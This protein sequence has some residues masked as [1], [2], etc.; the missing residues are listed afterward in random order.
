MVFSIL[1]ASMSSFSHLTIPAMC[2]M[3]MHAFLS[4]PYFPTW[5]SSPHS[6]V[7]LGS[8]ALYCSCT[9]LLLVHCLECSVGEGPLLRFYPSP[10]NPKEN[11]VD[12]GDSPA[13]LSPRDSLTYL[14]CM[15]S[16][17][18][19]SN[20][21]WWRLFG[22]FLVFPN[23]VHSTS[24]NYFP[25]IHYHPTTNLQFYPYRFVIDEQ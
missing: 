14:S 25:F 1:L 16:Q 21:Q 3:I 19:E 5:A 20:P 9:C 24:L 6:V 7:F 23:V 13:L 17:R 2:L 10:K 15:I 4:G 22:V 11:P 8:L 18:S 12:V